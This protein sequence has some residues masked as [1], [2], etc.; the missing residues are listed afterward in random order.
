MRKI[1]VIISIIICAGIVGGIFW[2]L[3]NNKKIVKNETEDIITENII[4]ESII[5]ENIIAESIIVEDIEVR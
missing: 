3:V 1:F 2:F 5:V 4:T